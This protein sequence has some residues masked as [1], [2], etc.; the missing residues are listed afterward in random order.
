MLFRSDSGDTDTGGR[1]SDPAPIDTGVTESPPDIGDATSVLY[2]R[3]L[4]FVAFNTYYS[5]S[6]GGDRT[7]WVLTYALYEGYYLAPMP[8]AGAGDLSDAA[9]AWPEMGVVEVADL[10][11][12]GVDDVVGSTSTEELGKDGKEMFFTV[13]W[14]VLP[15]PLA[16]TPGTAE[17]VS[18][19]AGN[20]AAWMVWETRAVGDVTGDGIADAFVRQGVDDEM[21]MELRKLPG[22]GAFAWEDAELYVATTFGADVA[23]IGDLT[24][25]GQADLALSAGEWALYEGPVSGPPAAEGALAALPDGTTLLAPAAA[26]SS[27]TSERGT[28]ARPPPPTDQ[29]AYQRLDRQR[30][31]R[32]ASSTTS[33]PVSPIHTPTAP[34][35]PHRANPMPSGSL[36]PH[37][38]AMDTMSVKRVS[39]APSSAR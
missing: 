6:L 27:T 38:S 20:P 11:G 22:P 4:S 33:S 14:W 3:D 2:D 28:A 17:A 8:A 12:D 30:H 39:P 37:D 35:P 10:D 29:R 26:C 16:G 24:G 32:S 36:S 25:D 9:V 19:L 23:A 31:V 5:E 18:H 21:R 1:D 7:P 13:D 34:Y 15:G